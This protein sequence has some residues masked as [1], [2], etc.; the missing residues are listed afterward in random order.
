M[1]KLPQK[2][3]TELFRTDLPPPKLEKVELPPQ[4]NIRVDVG[5]WDALWLLI[6]SIVRNKAR[7]AM[8]GRE[9]GVSVSPIRLFSAVGGWWMVGIGV[10]LL[11][12]FF[13]IVIRIR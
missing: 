12:I 13:H 3:P 2:K 4:K 5:F 11:F 1:K 7:D 9:V 8:E 10:V 6:K